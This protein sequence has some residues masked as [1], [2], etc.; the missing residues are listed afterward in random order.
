LIILAVREDK[1]SEAPRE[2]PTLKGFK[3]DGKLKMY[4]GVIFIFCLGNSSNTFLLLKAQ[5][6]G[7]SVSQ[8]ILLYF[9]F[10]ASASILAIPSGSCPTDLEGAEPLFRDICSTAL[11]ISALPFYRPNGNCSAVCCLR[12]V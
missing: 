12:R 4:L 10:N 9:I 3:L 6:Q 1:S 7:F 5:E 8:V 11:Y 2:K